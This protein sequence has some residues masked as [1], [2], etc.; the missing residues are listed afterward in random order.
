[1]D[2]ARATGPGHRVDRTTADAVTAR[3]GVAPGHFLL[4]HATVAHDA[5]LHRY[6][7]HVRPTDATNGLAMAPHHPTGQAITAAVTALLL[8]APTKVVL[9]LGLRPR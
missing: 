6:V 3:L 7:G 9:D 2:I 1:M 4:I 8:A 5:D